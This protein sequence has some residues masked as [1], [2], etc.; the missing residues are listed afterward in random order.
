MKVKVSVVIPCYCCSDTIVRA[1]DSVVSQTLSV[2][3]VVL[4]EDCSPDGGKTIALL[5]DLKEKYSLYFDV[6]MIVNKVNMGAAFSRNAG[7]SLATQAYIAFLDADD[8]WHPEKIRIQYEWM[9]KHPSCVLSGH[10]C[11]IWSGSDSSMYDDSVIKVTLLKKVSVM[12]KNPFSTPTVMLQRDIFFRFRDESRYAEDYLLWQQISYSGNF[13][14][15]IEFNL[16]YVHKGLYGAR[17]LSSHMWE[18]EK[19]DIYN[20]W[21]LYNQS[22]INVAVA[23]LLTIYSMLKYIRRVFNVLIRKNKNDE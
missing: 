23:S 6:K 17:G 9:L 20:Y 15:R 7:W 1:L 2:R 10:Q 5:N 11:E 22:L 16:A 21:I 8:S 4:V 14:A 12:L 13:V 3:E 18:M 19:A